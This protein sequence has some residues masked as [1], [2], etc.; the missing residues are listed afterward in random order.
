M[1]A[2]LDARQA[3]SGATPL[4]AAIELGR[5]DLADA[6]LAAGASPDA[7]D[8][9]GRSPAWTALASGQPD[10]LALLARRHARFDGAA[11]PPA[12]PSARRWHARPR[13]TSPPRCRRPARRS[14]RPARPGPAPPR[15]PARPPRAS[16]ATTTCAACAKSAASCC[17]RPM[18]VSIT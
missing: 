8:A 2:D 16:P 17:S 11:A 5:A 15:P 10:M 13:P 7:A 4:V 18:A 1:G 3:E 6:L 12:S 9:Q 14:S